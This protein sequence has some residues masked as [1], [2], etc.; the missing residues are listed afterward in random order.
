LAAPN[1]AVRVDVQSPFAQASS[2]PALRKRDRK[3]Q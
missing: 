1:P 3:P 2:T